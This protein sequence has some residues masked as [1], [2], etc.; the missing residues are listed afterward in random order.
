EGRVIQIE[1]IQSTVDLLAL[2]SDLDEEAE[3]ALADLSFVDAPNVKLSGSVPMD[4]P[5]LARLEVNYDHRQG[6]IYS[7]GGRS[8]PLSD[9]R[10]GFSFNQGVLETDDFA[11]SV[12]DGNVA[13]NGSVRL[14][15][16]GTPFS[17]LIEVSSLPLAKVGEY[18]GKGELGMTGNIFFDFRGIG[19]S[20]ISKIRGGGTI[21]VDEAKLPAFPVI[22]PVQKFLGAVVPA[23]GIQG[24][25]SLTGAYII[26]SGTLLTNDL[27]VAQAGALLV[28]NGSLNLDQQYVSF[29]TKA[30]LQPT[31]AT[32]TG[33]EDK[34]IEVSG[35]G[36]LT[37]P[38]LSL[39]GFPV[40]FAAGKLSEVLGTTPES[41][42]QL[43]GLISGEEDA[44]SILGAPLEEAIGE[45]LGGEVR[46][47]FE[48]IFGGDASEADPPVAAPVEGE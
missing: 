42:G 47:L 1:Q 46:G 44:A 2:A 40:D 33:M 9:L 35:E 45:E 43:K 32:A 39:S 25:G 3:E 6:I 22:G 41:L 27:T 38:S 10:G 31:L 37:S 19:Y 30:S 13:I 17:G 36:D 29:T 48:G 28:T 21:R 20:D 34:A 7:G 26:E 8:L 24:E 4:D 16:E 12:L 14:T 15:A 11:G 23:F 18:Y 5:K